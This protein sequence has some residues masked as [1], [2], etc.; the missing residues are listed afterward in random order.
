MWTAAMAGDWPTIA[1]IKPELLW[2]HQTGSPLFAPIAY[3]ALLRTR[4]QVWL[5]TFL[6]IATFLPIHY[7]FASMFPG[8][9]WI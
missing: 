5:F 1:D 2:I 4:V 3:F 8:V 6:M 7:I 9:P